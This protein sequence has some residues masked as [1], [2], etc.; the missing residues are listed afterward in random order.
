V[1]GV[2]YEPVRRWA[3]IDRVVAGSVTQRRPVL[4]GAALRADGQVET[5]EAAGQTDL[6]ICRTVLV[7]Q[8]GEAVAEATFR[9][10]L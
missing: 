8:S 9:V 6:A 7:D 5:V 10:V 2:L 1:A 3:G 4:L